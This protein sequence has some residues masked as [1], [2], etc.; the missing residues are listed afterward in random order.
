MAKKKSV[1]KSG[2]PSQQARLEHIKRKLAKRAKKKAERV[3]KMA[4]MAVGSDGEVEE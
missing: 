2:A 4:K 3:V 1:V